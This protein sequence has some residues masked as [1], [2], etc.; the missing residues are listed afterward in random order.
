LEKE[1]ILVTGASGYIASRLIPQLLERG[2]RVRALARYPLRLA[3]RSWSGRVELVAGDVL[4]PSTLPAALEGVQTAYYLIHN[5]LSGRGYIARE[6][7]SARN[8]AYAAGVAGLDHIIY[9][10]GLADPHQRIA[11]HMRSRIETGEV[12]RLGKVSVTELRAGV[13]VG[14]GSIS[15]EMIRFMTEQFPLL[16]GPNWLKNKSQPIATQNVLD[17]L[18]A[19]LISPAGRGKIIE[20]GGPDI[21]A[22]G[23]LMLIYARLRGLRRWQLTFRDIP[24][25]LMAWWVDKLTPVPFPIARALVDSLRSDSVVKDDS[26][27]KLFPSVNLIQYGEAV[28]SSLR[29]LNP[30]QLEP[31]WKD[32]P[33]AVRTI[34]HEGF[35]IDHRSLDVAASP[36]AIY[37]VLTSMG[38]RR[39]WPFVNW[40]LS[41]RGWLDKLFGGPGLRGRPDILR[42]GDAIDYHRIDA[43]EPNHGMRLHS[44]LRQ[45]GDGWL[46]WAIDMESAQ[47]SI[48]MQTAFFAPRGLPGYLYWYL[49]APWHRMALR[50]TIHGIKIRS[51]SL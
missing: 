14:P 40:L 34:K 22:Y 21:K 8:F 50:G 7:E 5:M 27:R 24:V 4:R 38:G 17:Y 29:N 33:G 2:Y 12:L 44:E 9:L 28:A 37:S 42:T 31:V 20:I 41:V 23:D 11:P 32:Y 13:I 35:F 19:A 47:S 18:Q 26:A 25:W 48:L 39:G 43:L 36:E 6:V 49:L 30:T 15:F 45:P 1:L 51:E 3:G 10:G 46:E 16:P